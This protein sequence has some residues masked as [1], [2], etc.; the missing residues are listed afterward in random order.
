LRIEGAFN[1]AALAAVFCGR[2]FQGNARECAS[3]KRAST[4]ASRVCGS[5]SFGGDLLSR[6]I[7]R[8]RLIYNQIF[9]VSQSR[10]I[11]PQ[12]RRGIRAAGSGDMS[13]RSPAIR[14]RSA[15]NHLSLDVSVKVIASLMQR[16]AA[17]YCPSSA[18]ARAKSDKRCGIDIVVPIDR[19]S[20]IPEVSIWTAL[21]ALP[22]R[23]Y[24]TPCQ[25]VPATFQDKAPFFSARAASS[26]AC[27]ADAVLC[28]AAPIAGRMRA[29]KLCDAVRLLVWYRKNRPGRR[30]ASDVRLLRLWG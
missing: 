24:T 11:K 21:E 28:C 14:W 27:A 2:Q 29:G 17:S 8:R 26:W 20:V 9:K 23:A 13:V 7:I 18:W 30:L 16:Q 4:S 19:N 12:I 1:Q 22:V 25:D 15:S 6:V 3:G 10:P 5:T